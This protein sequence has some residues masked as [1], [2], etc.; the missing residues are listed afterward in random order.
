[1]KV[2]GD[3]L[4]WYWGKEDAKLL[5]DLISEG[6]RRI[7]LSKEKNYRF[8]SIINRIMKAIREAD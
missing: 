7:P 6:M 1:M 4:G 2:I 3:W 8:N 5:A